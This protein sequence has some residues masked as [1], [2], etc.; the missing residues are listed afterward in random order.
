MEKTM[1]RNRRSSNRELRRGF[2]LLEVI[3]AVT[4]VALLATILLPNLNRFLRSAKADKARAE[5]NSLANQVRLYIATETTGDLSDDFTLDMLLEGDDPYLNNANEL[6]DPWES[7][8]VII[9]PGD[10]N[11]DFDVM[12][13]G[14]DGQSGGNDDIVNG[15]E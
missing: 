9:I 10:R 6:V 3:I 13:F 12:S 4:I 8:Y 15:K 11:R 7:P 14:P 2:S 5:V 1:N